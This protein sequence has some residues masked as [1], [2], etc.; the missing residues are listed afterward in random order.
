MARHAR[1]CGSFLRLTLRVILLGFLAGIAT[2]SFAQ[3]LGGAGTVEG[4]VKDPTGGVMQAVEV[5]ISNPVSGFARTSTTDAMGR[6]VFRSL[7]PPRSPL[8]VA[9]QG[10][11]PLERD[12]NVRSAVPIDVD[13]SLALAGTTAAVDVVGH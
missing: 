7:P 12:V 9:A 13:L 10:F 3:E 4:T 2:T 6:F 5:K 11:Q 1:R 8:G